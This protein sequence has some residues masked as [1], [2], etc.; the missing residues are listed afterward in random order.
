MSDETMLLSW[1]AIIAEVRTEDLEEYFHDVIEMIEDNIEPDKQGKV[2][3]FVEAFK[4][5]IV[6]DRRLE[7]W[8]DQ[9]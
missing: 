2:K 1:I 8:E 9:T 7:K 3:K 5:I 6:E 4:E